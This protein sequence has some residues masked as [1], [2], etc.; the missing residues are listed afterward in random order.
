[1]HISEEYIVCLGRRNN[2][3]SRGQ[4][5]WP[6]VVLQENLDYWYGYHLG[7][8]SEVNGAPSQFSKNEWNC[9]HTVNPYNQL[10]LDDLLYLKPLIKKPLK[11][12]HCGSTSKA[13][14]A[15]AEWRLRD[16]L[17]GMIVLTIGADTK[18][19][20]TAI[21]SAKKVEL[22]L[23]HLAKIEEADLVR[24]LNPGRYIG[25]STQRELEYAQQLKKRI[26]FLEPSV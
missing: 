6:I 10:S 20:D 18:D 5:I 9:I 19:E 1:M 11:V 4:E 16:T 3:S 17:D 13:A 25:A 26:W 14:A 15:F 2:S 21:G 7:Q 22:D 12:C 8:A 24:I 23:L